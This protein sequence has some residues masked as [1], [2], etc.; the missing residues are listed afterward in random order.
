ME[1]LNKM[2]LT[3]IAGASGAYDPAY[4]GAGA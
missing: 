3:F 2:Q 1:M 4:A